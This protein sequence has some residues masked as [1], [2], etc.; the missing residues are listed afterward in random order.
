MPLWTASLMSLIKDAIVEQVEVR[1]AL[2]SCA[3]AYRHEQDDASQ[4]TCRAPSTLAR[5]S[6]WHVGVAMCDKVVGCDIET[7]NQLAM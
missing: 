3:Q 5:C 7:L 2:V 6:K 1:D 4:P